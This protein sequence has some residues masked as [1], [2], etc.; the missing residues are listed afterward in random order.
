MSESLE[1]YAAI[2]TYGCQTSNF[3]PPGGSMNFYT[4]QLVPGMVAEKL[5]NITLTIWKNEAAVTD[6]QVTY[7]SERMKE[8]ANM[9]YYKS[10]KVGCSYRACTTTFAVAC[11]FNSA[12]EIGK[13]IYMGSSFGSERMQCR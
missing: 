6:G 5:I 4:D 2:N 12:P 1:L 13:P 8:F 9:L 7:T 11:V 10:T 3:V